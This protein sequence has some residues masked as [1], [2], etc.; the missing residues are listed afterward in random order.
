M[1]E[2]CLTLPGKKLVISDLLF[3]KKFRHRGG[4]IGAMEAFR[5]LETDG[6]GRLIPVPG[7]RVSDIAKGILSH[8]GQQGMQLVII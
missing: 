4:K 1:E 6:L 8:Q 5:N 2:F 7:G 3:G